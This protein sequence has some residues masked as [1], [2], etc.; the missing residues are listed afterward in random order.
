MGRSPGALETLDAAEAAFGAMG[1]EA[2]ALERDSR[3]IGLLLTVAAGLAVLSLLLS[4]GLRK[5]PLAGALTAALAGLPA[6]ACFV[7]W[8]SR[9]G[10]L[11]G[12]LPLAAAILAV[13]AA[14][15]AE[16]LFRKRRGAG[17]QF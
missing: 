14:V 6:A 11:G 17:K 4:L 3:G 9:C 7:L 5:K 1:R 15:F 10:E 12:Y 8:R 13:L 2:E 16:Q